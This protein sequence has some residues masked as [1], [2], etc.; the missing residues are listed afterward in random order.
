MTALLDAKA[1]IDDVND[2]LSKHVSEVKDVVV[3]TKREVDS[4]LK[5]KAGITLVCSAKLASVSS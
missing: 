1:D 5:A 2:L 4:K 3:S